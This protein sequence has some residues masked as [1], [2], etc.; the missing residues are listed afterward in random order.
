MITEQRPASPRPAAPDR[1]DALRPATAGDGH[2]PS[3]AVA[4]W[5][6][7]VTAVAVTVAAVFLMVGAGALAQLALAPLA[8]GEPDGTPAAFGLMIGLG[9][10]MTATALGVVAL[11]RRAA[12]LPFRGVGLAPWRRAWLVLPAGAVAFAVVAASWWSAAA[13]G[14]GAWRFDQFAGTPIWLIAVAPILPL[15]SQAFPEELLFRGNLMDVLARRLAP[16]ATI[17][18]SAIAFGALHLLSNAP[19]TTPFEQVLYALAAA[20]FGFTAAALRWTTGSVWGA[21][22]VHFGLHAAFRLLPL[23]PEAYLVAPI[24][25][26]VGFVAAGAVVLLVGRARSRRAVETVAPLDN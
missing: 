22:G 17:L 9:I 12:R 24:V 20:A 18:T 26:I 23:E 16:L 3:R 7:P 19:T 2:A 14:E 15:L 8:H 25:Q 4:F 13:T 11:Y 6:H 10:V 21:V 1:A 5:R